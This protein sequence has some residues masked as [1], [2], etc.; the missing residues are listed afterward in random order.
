MNEFY[1]LRNRYFFIFVSQ[2]ETNSKV[3]MSISLSNQVCDN[4]RI[5]E[6]SVHTILYHTCNAIMH[7]HDIFVDG[8]V[9]YS[10]FLFQG[11]S[12]V[13]KESVT[14]ELPTMCVFSKT[15]AKIVQGE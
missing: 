11:R 15:Y 8:V 14:H 2:K 6:M 1:N 13:R 5:D 3:W 4:R 9:L 10:P 12:L 7:G